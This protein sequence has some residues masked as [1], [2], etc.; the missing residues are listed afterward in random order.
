MITTGIITSVQNIPSMAKYGFGSIFFYMLVVIVFLIPSALISAELATG[1]PKDGGVYVWVREA[2]GQRFGFV[3]IWMQFIE[4]A[5]WLPSILTVTAVTIAYVWNPELQNNKWFVILTVNG[6]IWAMTLLNLMGMG[7]SGIIATIGTIGGRILPVILLVVLGIAFIVRGNISN[8]QFDL[9]T[10]VPDLTNAGNLVFAAGAFLTF[11]G[12]EVSASNAGS[13]RNP[14]RDFPRAILYSSAIAFVVVAGSTIALAVMVPVE[15]LS[16]V[17]GVMDAFQ[18]ALSLFSLEWLV[19]VVAILMAAG[20]IAEISNWIVGPT[21]GL[22]EA[23]FDGNIP[24]FFHRVNARAVPSRILIGQGLFVSAASIAFTIFPIQEAF[25]LLTALP[26]ML[27]L[28]MYVLM[29]ISGIRLRYTQPDV[30]RTYRVPLG[31]F[32]MWVA[33][34]VGTVAALV[35]IFVAFLPPPGLERGAR[36]P[37]LFATIAGFIVLSAIPF[38]IYQLRRPNWHTRKGEF[39]EPF[40]TFNTDTEE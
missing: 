25:W 2:L 26:V 27:Y 39:D 8:I 19:A 20:M 31:N 15:N 37:Y 5:V 11:A 10:F 6:I 16:L 1:W 32:G 12:I 9:T 13:V 35:A 36:G 23:G 28:V 18:A 21:R 3:A 24:K 38:V 30:R 33:S 22:L 4:N 17:A 29:F 34:I 14:R 40:V 7:T